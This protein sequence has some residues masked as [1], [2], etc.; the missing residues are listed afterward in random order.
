MRPTNFLLFILILLTGAGCLESS[1]SSEEKRVVI[2]FTADGVGEDVVA[3]N[4]TLRVEEFKFSLDRFNL[5]AA[6]DV[7]L[8][9]SSDVTALIF[10]YNEQINGERLILDVGLGFKDVT[11]FSGY[12]I[13]L[14]PV[15]NRG[16]ILDDDFFG[17]GQ[18]YSVIIKGDVNGNNFVFR[19][20]Q[21][22]QKMFEIS[23]VSLDSENE[24]LVLRKTID[25]EDVL[26]NQ[27]GD[28]IDPENN[29]NESQIVNNIEAGLTLEASAETFF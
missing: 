29:E 25:L 6:N 11:D 16:N 22:F 28:L 23:N 26:I 18:N 8:Q 19:S 13:F 24:T 7:V 9:T 27:E 10:G 20:S 3:G 15:E 1:F 5:H 4:D 21:S 14:E 12:E 17:D 2:F